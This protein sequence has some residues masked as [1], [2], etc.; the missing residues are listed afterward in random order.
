[1][2]V[3]HRCCASWND[4]LTV[5]DSSIIQI[6]CFFPCCLTAVILCPCFRWA[7]VWEHYWKLSR[8]PFCLTLRSLCHSSLQC[9]SVYL[10]WTSETRCTQGLP[11]YCIILC[12]FLY[13]LSSTLILNVA[14][15]M[16]GNWCKWFVQAI[17]MFGCLITFS[18]ETTDTWRKEGCDLHFWR[19][20]W[21]M[22]RSSNQVRYSPDFLFWGLNLF[23]VMI[24]SVIIDCLMSWLLV[25]GRS[26]NDPY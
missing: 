14:N 11:D 19:C 3:S 21:A 22:S 18:G 1:M 2:V 12:S 20:C 24:S 4:L 10:W 8:Q 25:W 17:D 15:I 16:F 26:I 6:I 23:I 9:W 5:P 7:S 13:A